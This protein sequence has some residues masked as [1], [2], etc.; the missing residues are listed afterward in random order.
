V[1]CVFFCFVF[2]LV[3]LQNLYLSLSLFNSSTLPALAEQTVTYPAYVVILKKGVSSDCIYQVLSGECE[4]RY[5][6]D[7]DGLYSS[8]VTVPVVRCLVRTSFCLT[9]L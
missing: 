1:F 5:P 6:T 8:G 9:F 7:I 2:L 3:F 4:I